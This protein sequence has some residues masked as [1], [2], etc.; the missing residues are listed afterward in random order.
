MH[1]D[2]LH[3]YPKNICCLI[4]SK[5][6]LDSSPTETNSLGSREKYLANALPT[7]QSKLWYHFKSTENASNLVGVA[8]LPTNEAV[9][10]N[11]K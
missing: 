7:W 9:A 3:S 4:Y 11:S 2:A 8:I 6:I 10:S 1:V 5:D